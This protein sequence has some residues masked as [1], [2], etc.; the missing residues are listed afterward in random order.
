M[1]AK[2]WF[3]KTTGRAIHF[4][5]KTNSIARRLEAEGYPSVQGVN[6][7][8]LEKKLD[9]DTRKLVDDPIY[10]QRRQQK[11]ERK[12]QAKQRFVELKQALNDPTVDFS[13]PAVVKQ[14]F[15]RTLNLFRYIASRLEE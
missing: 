9:L 2:S 7:R 5:K 12:E 8:V 6:A 1:A 14:A 3:D 4:T 11:Q 13:N 15:N 10:E